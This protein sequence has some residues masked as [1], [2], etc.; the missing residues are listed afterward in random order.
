MGSDEGVLFVFIVQQVI[1]VPLVVPATAAVIVVIAGH[2]GSA[3][4]AAGKRRLGGPLAQRV[5]T[6]VVIPVTQSTSL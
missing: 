2:A 4:W 3:G 6:L 1:V 5:E